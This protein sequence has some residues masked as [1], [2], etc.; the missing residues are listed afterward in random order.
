MWVGGWWVGG[1]GW[2]GMGG[3]VWVWVGVGGCGWVW[4]GGW[5][6]GC[7][8]VGGW[9]GGWVW[10]WVWVCVC[11]C[12]CASTATASKVKTEIPSSAVSGESLLLGCAIA[13]LNCEL[14]PFCRFGCPSVLVSEAA[15]VQRPNRRAGLSWGSRAPVLALSSGSGFE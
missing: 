3:W 15:P 2:V 13:A 6:G 7:G 4:V 10:V 12:D 8:W 9:V 14:M 5:V 1:C 11:V